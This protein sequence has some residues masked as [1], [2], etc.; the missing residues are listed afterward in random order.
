MICVMSMTLHGHDTHERRTP[1]VHVTSDPLQVNIF[2]TSDTYEWRYMDMTQM[3]DIITHPYH[4]FASS[5]IRNT[6]LTCVPPDPIIMYVPLQVNI[7]QKSILRTVQ[8]KYLKSCSGDFYS[9][10][11]DPPHKIMRYWVYH[12]I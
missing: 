3:S 2:H 1:H 8:Y 9:P 11:S 12:S 6:S 5:L 10:A 4:I 7:F